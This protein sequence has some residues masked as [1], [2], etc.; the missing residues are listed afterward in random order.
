MHFVQ[1]LTQTFRAC[2][3]DVAVETRFRPPENHLPIIQHQRGRHFRIQ[4]HV[5]GWLIFCDIPFPGHGSETIAGVRATF[6]HP[7]TTWTYMNDS[8]Q[9]PWHWQDYWKFSV[10]WLHLIFSSLRNTTMCKW[11]DVWFSTGWGFV[12]RMAL[13]VSWA[14]ITLRN[15]VT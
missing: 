7:S 13:G 2:W 12:K 4:T 8:V 15:I 9:N 5:H 10:C 6:A 1:H 11:V 3:K 14:E